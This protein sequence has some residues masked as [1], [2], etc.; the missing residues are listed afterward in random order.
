[1][2]RRQLDNVEWTASQMIRYRSAKAVVILA[3]G[4]AQ[5]E[6]YRVFW[7]G[8]SDSAIR[9][10]K[11]IMYMHGDSHR[12]H[13]N[14][15]FWKALNILR[16]V[17]AR[18]GFEDPLEVTVDTSLEDPFIF[19]RRVLTPVPTSQPTESKRPSSV[20]SA[21]PSS[22]PTSVPTRLPSRLPSTEPSVIP[23]HIPSVQPSLSPSLIPTSRP[24]SKEPTPKPS[25]TPTSTPSSPP[26]LQ[27]T[28]TPTNHP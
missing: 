24:T 11:P 26:S 12:W 8:V 4:Y 6:N 9:F 13:V 2:I 15:P 16:V 27:P 3:H 22:S 23:S 21:I 18:S 14:R 28:P 5:L 7:Q 19:K 1:M 25:R 17:V 20:P 10:K